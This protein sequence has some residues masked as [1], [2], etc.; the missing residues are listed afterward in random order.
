VR[1][2]RVNRTHFAKLAEKHGTA[3]AA[4][5]CGIS[6]RTARR[7][8]GAIR[9]EGGAVDIHRG[10]P[11]SKPKPKVLRERVSFAKA[12][13]DEAFRRLI[14]T[15]FPYP[16]TLSQE[17]IAVEFNRLVRYESF[18][19]RNMIRMKTTIGLPI[20]YPFFPNRYDARSNGQ[21]TAVEA[22]RDKTALRAAIRLQLRYGDPTV[23]HRVLRA[24]TLRCRTP[25]VFRPAVAKFIYERY[26]NGG[27][28]WDP[29][30][31]YGGRLLGAAAARV[32]YIGTDVE[33]ATVKGNLALAKALGFQAQLTCCPAEEFNPP[34]ELSLVFTSPPYFDREQYS[35][36]EK[37][38]WKRYASLENWVGGFLRPVVER[39][40]RRLGSNGKLV[41]NIADIRRRNKE[42]VP[43]VATTIQTALASGF[44]HVET[45][46]MPI[47]SINRLSA[48]EPILVFEK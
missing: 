17:E 47:G 3:M 10:R 37:Q 29:C 38:S 41:L 30:S 27:V 7:V 40:K 13:E 19:E 12:D 8:I 2:I 22:W 45:L 6:M 35:D 44:H 11:T 24:V 21:L 39:A 28:V 18:L 33:T 31:G 46:Q 32:Q 43:L 16:T 4:E 20:C 36:G 5:R 25:T 26:A 1:K 48:S 14:H 15:P 23:A 34:R 9:V 42:V